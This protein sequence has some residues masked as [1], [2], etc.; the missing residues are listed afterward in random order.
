MQVYDFHWCIRY[1]MY[2]LNMSLHIWPLESKLI[3]SNMSWTSLIS[4]PPFRLFKQL[5]ISYFMVLAFLKS[6]FCEKFFS[7]KKSISFDKTF[8]I[9]G[10]SVYF[11]GLYCRIECFKENFEFL[12]TL[13]I[14]GMSQIDPHLLQFRKL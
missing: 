8:P 10:Y 9:L 14:L 12:L 1:C 5:K 3:D 6:L 2:E 4:S 7:S 13:C 11:M